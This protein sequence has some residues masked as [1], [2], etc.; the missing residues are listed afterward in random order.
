SPLPRIHGRCRH[1]RTSPP[2]R[3]RRSPRPRIHRRR[4][5]DLSPPVPF[6]TVHRACSRPRPSPSTPK[7]AQV[8]TARGR[9][10]G[11][12][13]AVASAQDG[14][15]SNRSPVWLAVSLVLVLL[16]AAGAFAAFRLPRLKSTAAGE[17]ARDLAEGQLSSDIWH[18]SDLAQGLFDRV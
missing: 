10:R 7:A 1:A 17:A 16:I 14:I 6:R 4:R 3:R 2:L 15:M 18:D 8:E 12:D 11:M 5:R 13:T 9:R